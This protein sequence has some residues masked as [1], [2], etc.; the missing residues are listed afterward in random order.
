MAKKTDKP[1]PDPT[2][3]EPIVDLDTSPAST[4]ADADADVAQGAPVAEPVKPFNVN[5][6]LIKVQGGKKYLPVAFRLVW[7][8]N[9]HPDWLIITNPH[10]IN[11]EKQY[12]IFKAEICNAEGTIVAT[13]FKMEDVKGFRDYIE[14]A[15]TGSIGRALAVCGY[16]TQFAPELE[17][18]ERLADSPVGS[19][20]TTINAGDSK[21]TEEDPFV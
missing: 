21:V 10:E 13:G 12:A 9:D 8:R 3:G 18:G 7:F 14:K 16:G 17:E 20:W 6:H 1:L 2:L 19:S 11:I 15:E 4:G 5:D